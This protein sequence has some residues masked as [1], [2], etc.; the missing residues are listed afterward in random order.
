MRDVLFVGAVVFILFLIIQNLL[1]TFTPEQYG[2]LVRQGACDEGYLM[3]QA[4]EDESSAYVPMC[5]PYAED[6][7]DIC[8]QDDDCTYD[9]IVSLDDLEA[10]GCNTEA[11]CGEPSPCPKLRG[12]CSYAPNTLDRSIPKKEHIQFF[13]E[14]PPTH[15]EQPI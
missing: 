2:P 14:I 13:C 9:C 1:Q 4:W 3:T 8:K 15:Q 6:G 10:L 12:R 11:P 7:G 5:Y